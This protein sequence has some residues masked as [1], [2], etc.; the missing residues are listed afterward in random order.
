MELNFERLE[1]LPFAPTQFGLV[2][3]VAFPPD[4]TELIVDGIVEARGALD[5]EGQFP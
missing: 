1:L 3:Q 2:E 4:P 5:A